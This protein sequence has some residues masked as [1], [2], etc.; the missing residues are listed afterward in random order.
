MYEDTPYDQNGPNLTIHSYK[1]TNGNNGFPE[2]AQLCVLQLRS[3]MSTTLCLFLWSYVNLN[4]FKYIDT[5][6]KLNS[7]DMTQVQKP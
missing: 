1:T 3:K 2:L 7:L 5:E 6:S 4:L